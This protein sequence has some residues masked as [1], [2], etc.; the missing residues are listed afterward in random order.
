V[1]ELLFANGGTVEI[2]FADLFYTERLLG[3]GTSG[4]T[5]A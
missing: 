5:S 2:G 1:H 3:T 4:L